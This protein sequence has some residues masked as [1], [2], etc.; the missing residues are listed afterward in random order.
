MFLAY[1]K[2][3]KLLSNICMSFPQTYGYKLKTR[4]I[5]I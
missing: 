1:V 3:I 2:K 4:M 5:S